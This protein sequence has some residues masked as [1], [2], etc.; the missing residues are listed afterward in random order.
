MFKWLNS[1]EANSVVQFSCTFKTK[2][3]LK[4]PTHD[5]IIEAKEVYIHESFGR[6]QGKLVLRN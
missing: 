5:Y 3:L 2:V 1:Y 4:K 6:Y